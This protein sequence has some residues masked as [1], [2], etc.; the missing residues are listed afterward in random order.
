MP[1]CSIK[2][3]CR[4]ARQAVGCRL[5]TC[6]LFFNKKS[7]KGPFRCHIDDAFVIDRAI[8]PYFELLVKAFSIKW[9]IL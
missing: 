4:P 2:A 9:S 3:S 5:R 1:A 8:I 7:D 6:V